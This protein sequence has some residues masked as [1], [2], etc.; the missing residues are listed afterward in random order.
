MY[1]KCT[2]CG[3]VK[4]IGSFNKDTYTKSGFCGTCRSCR[5]ELQKRQRRAVREQPPKA[6]PH[7]SIGTGSEISFPA[8]AFATL[9]EA[10]SWFGKWVEVLVLLEKI[11]TVLRGKQ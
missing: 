7:V 4:A 3:K 2:K 5:R 9:P 8:Q 1:Q 10:V 11:E 6:E